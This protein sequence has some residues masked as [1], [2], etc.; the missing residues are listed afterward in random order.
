M[1]QCKACV[2]ATYEKRILPLWNLT[3]EKILS[4]VATLEKNDVYY[5]V[6]ESVV[7]FLVA[8]RKQALNAVEWINK[9]VQQI[10]S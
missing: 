5:K 6:H 9:N 2:V 8:S 3:Q 10:M 7:N 1:V 4:L